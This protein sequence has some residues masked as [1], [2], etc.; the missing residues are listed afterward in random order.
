MTEEHEKCFVIS[1]ATVALLQGVRRISDFYCG[2]SCRPYKNVTVLCCL[3]PQGKDTSEAD[4]KEGTHSG[5]GPPEIY[6]WTTWE[7]LDLKVSPCLEKYV[8]ISQKY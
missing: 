3:N 6:P 5:L 7:S 2:E 4:E 1:V 8:R